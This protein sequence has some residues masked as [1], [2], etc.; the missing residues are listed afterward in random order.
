MG[1]VDSLY[2]DF[3]KGLFAVLR[4]DVKLGMRSALDCVLGATAQSQTDE[5]DTRW[6]RRG[7]EPL[8]RRPWSTQVGQPTIPR[9]LTSKMWKTAT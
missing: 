1:S 3:P 7:T 4:D 2:G 8:R 6:S 5:L 9:A